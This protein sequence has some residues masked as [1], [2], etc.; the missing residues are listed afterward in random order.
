MEEKHL[1]GNLK[2]CIPVPVHASWYFGLL[3][4]FLVLD[5]LL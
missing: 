1:N 3:N 5:F 4:S 2:T